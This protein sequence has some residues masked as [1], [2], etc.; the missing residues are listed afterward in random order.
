MKRNVITSCLTFFI[1]LLLWSA[2]VPSPSWASFYTFTH[3]ADSITSTNGLTFEQ[4]AVGQQYSFTI[5]TSEIFVLGSISYVRLYWTTYNE[6]HAIGRITA[7][8]NTVYDGELNVINQWNGDTGPFNSDYMKYTWLP[9]LVND[10][11]AID[12]TLQNTGTSMWQFDK[13]IM[14]AAGTDRPAVPI[15]STIFLLIPGLAALL[16][17]RKKSK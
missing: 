3:D 9:S 14:V 17:I 15:P 11:G 13:L 10:N 12:F 6:G 16:V 7:D 4:L 5:D 8:S 2:T 1:I